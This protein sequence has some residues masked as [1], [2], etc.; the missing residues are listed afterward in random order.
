MTGKVSH[1]SKSQID[2]IEDPGIHIVNRGLM[3]INY[4]K[5]YITKKLIL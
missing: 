5:N 1:S 4:F 2:Q 3:Y